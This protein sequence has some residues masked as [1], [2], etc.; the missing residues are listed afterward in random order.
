[1]SPLGQDLDIPDVFIPLTSYCASLGSIIIQYI[2]IMYVCLYL[3]KSLSAMIEHNQDTRRVTHSHQMPS[4]SLVIIP[5]HLCNE[6][7]IITAGHNRN[8]PLDTSSPSP[9]HHPIFWLRSALAHSNS[10]LIFPYSISR[11]TCHCKAV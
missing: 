5:G 7:I 6:T 11:H 1:M 9:I 10:V 3:H 8:I 4:S 2:H